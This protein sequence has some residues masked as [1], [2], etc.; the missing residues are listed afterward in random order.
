M[1][2]TVLFYLCYMTSILHRVTLVYNCRLLIII[3]LLQVNLAPNLTLPD[4]VL[5]TVVANDAN[6]SCPTCCNLTLC[7]TK[8]QAL[9]KSFVTLTFTEGVHYLQGNIVLDNYDEFFMT[10]FS[11]KTVDNHYNDLMMSSAIIDCR[12]G[13]GGLSFHNI[14]SV[15]IFNL[16]FKGCSLWI[17]EAS[18]D[19]TLVETVMLDSPYRA[20]TIQ[21]SHDIYVSHCSFLNNG[22]NND[23]NSK[24]C[25]YN[26]NQDNGHLFIYNNGSDARFSVEYTNFTNGC[27]ST[28]GGGLRILI[29]EYQNA[30]A[31]VGNN[32]M[33]VAYCIFD[34]NTAPFG[35]NMAVQI[36][37][38]AQHKQV[39]STIS[40]L[41]CSFIQGNS[42]DENDSDCW[43]YDHQ[44]LGSGG[45]EVHIATATLWNI[46]I[47]NS[48]FVNNT[49]CKA[50]GGFAAYISFFSE[51]I[52]ANCIFNGNK[53]TWNGR[54]A[55]YPHPYVTYY[56]NIIV[57]YATNINE[58]TTTRITI[59][60][61]TFVNNEAK[62]F[63][64]GLTIMY[65]V[66]A[67][68][69]IMDCV[70]TA[71]NGAILYVYIQGLSM[72]QKLT[73]ISIGNTS[74]TNNFLLRYHELELFNAAVVMEAPKASN[75]YFNN[76]NISHNKMTG[77][78]V[79]GVVILFDG[80][81]IICNNSSPGNYGGAMQLM[82]IKSVHVFG[83]LMIV[84][85]T[86]AVYGGGIF[87]NDDPLLSNQRSLVPGIKEGCLIQL[88]TAQESRII[89][90][91]NIAGITG[92]DLF[93]G[94]FYAC[95]HVGRETGI[96]SSDYFSF[97]YPLVFLNCSINH[98]WS[99]DN[100][101]NSSVSSLPGL[102]C[103]CI[104][105]TMDCTIRSMQYQV[106]PAQ[107]LALDVVTVGKCGGV[108]PGAVLT[109]IHGGNYIPLL[110]EK[111]QLKGTVCP[112]TT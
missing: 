4:L 83:T 54:V 103:L 60:Q 8:L 17:G 102:V 108:S 10:S 112:F 45:I 65:V 95:A 101:D 37:G 35:G 6:I 93:G 43:K 52:I 63:A 81:N 84:G 62:L 16:S 41:N 73:S 78:A 70:F 90:K 68:I 33:D 67:D 25:F 97:N 71:N 42:V 66:V 77:I 21:N 36:F 14:T 99:Y 59:T 91:D 50:A 92:N 13:L 38:D 29:K 48:T 12:F 40:I 2:A 7:I 18:H 64:A 39:D 79:V 61:S 87:I 80:N 24:N 23:Y 28:L 27:S 89:F 46:T 26:S 85:N 5:Y 104:N 56:Q 44:E 88:Q 94:T 106:Y 9:N 31:A 75:I 110:K 57:S 76:S 69:I 86:A 109:T 98:Y 100:T 74:I 105:S 11:K 22:W 55:I 107:T 34:N 53:G 20:I 15:F 58:K 30:T 72:S 49:A 51:I 82:A 47:F 3:V 19:V 32:F 96:F 111:L 1:H